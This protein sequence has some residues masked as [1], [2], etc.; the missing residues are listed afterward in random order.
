MQMAGCDHTAARILAGESIAAADRPPLDLANYIATKK[1]YLPLFLYSGSD[2]RIAEAGRDVL[3]AF[4]ESE[5]WT[6]WNPKQTRRA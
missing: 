2:V 1:G 6:G 3:L 5:V 4:F